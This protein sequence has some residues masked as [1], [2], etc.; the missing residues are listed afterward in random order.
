M[1]ARSFILFYNTFLYPESEDG[2]MFDTMLDSGLLALLQQGYR[3][4]WQQYLASLDGAHATMPGWDICVLTASNAHQADAYEAQLEVRRKAGLLPPSTRFQVIPD[5]DGTRLGSGGATLRVLAELVRQQPS[6][7]AQPQAE[8]PFVG[9]RVL[10]IHSGGDSRRLPHCSAIGK[11]FA[12]VPHQL[13]DGRPSSLFDEFLVSLSGLPAQ[14]PEGILV[15]SGDVLLFFDHLQLSFARPGVIGVA[16]AAPADTATHHGV[17]VTTETSHHIRAFLHKPSLQRLRDE[18]AIQADSLVPVDTGLV[19]L[20]RE[21]ATKALSLADRL[22]DDIAQGATINLYGDLLMPLAQTTDRSPYLTDTSD[23][24]ATPALQNARRVIWET[25]R[26]TPFSV[27]RLHPALFVHFGTTREYLEVLQQGVKLLGACGWRDQAASWVASAPTS[28]VAARGVAINTVVQDSVPPGSCL[29]DSCLETQ[30]DLGPGCLLANV[31]TERAALALGPDT[32]LH[33]LPL[34]DVEGYVTRLLGASDDP[35]CAIEAGGTFLNK[36]WTA[37]LST[38]RISVQD[39]WPDAQDVSGCTLWDARL[40][41][42]CT[43]REE[44]L[45]LVLWMQSPETVSPDLLARWRAKPRLSLGESYAQ[46]DVRRIVREQGEIEDRVRARHFYAGLERELPAGELVPLLGRSSDAPRRARLVADWLEASLDP[47]LPIRGYRALAIASHETRWEE[48]AFSSLARLVRAHTFLPSTS[49]SE[50]GKH[51]KISVHAAARLDFG[52]G[53]SDTPPYSLERGGMVLNAAITLWDQHPIVAEAALLDEPS[54]IL[55]CR[56]IEAT[57]RPRFVGDILNYAN[58]ADPFALHKAALVFRGIIPADSAPQAE[59]ADIL[60][61]LGHGLHL[62]T[63]TSIPRGSGL[64]TS[65]I[66]AGTILQCLAKLLAQ[67]LAQDQLCEHVLCLEQMITTGGGWQ[68]QVGGLV[69]GIKLTATQPGLPQIMRIEMLPITPS[70]RTALDERLMVV[71]TGQRRLAKGLLRAIMGRF[72]ARDPEMVSMLKEITDLA[73][74]MRQALMAEDLNTFGA[75]IG[76]H[77]EINKCMDPGCT[78]PF[79]DHLL[80]SCTPYMVGAKLAGAGGGG[81]AIVVA[82]AGASP[83]LRAALQS[84]FPQR[85]VAIWPCQVAKEGLV[86]GV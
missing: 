37:W 20:D 51:A 45:D 22:A 40:Y 64:G 29:S 42:I 25:L 12:R 26:G 84:R 78:N 46:A 85:D 57:L 76:Q 48:R 2:T 9:Q 47:W 13:P 3:N 79:I 82:R 44:S 63:A 5:P 43:S 32:L 8:P 55:E 69:G 39:L 70:L 71:Y 10:I 38:A 50:T 34:R 19:W 73:C 74:Q 56:D 30:L 31:L 24:P 14:I 58:P 75:L 23:G 1:H 11:L 16:V 27:E 18:G 7:Q 4:N 66:L 83:A 21:T 41:P 53:W 15:A 81:F 60:R 61:P 33:Q 80:A 17:Y 65:S 28:P 49:Y 62:A 72:M 59:L 54:L 68:D 35:K 36:P 6:S 77:W 67:P 52:G 86:D